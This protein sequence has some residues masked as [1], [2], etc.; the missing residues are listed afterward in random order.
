MSFDDA[1]NILKGEDHA[2]TDYL[3]RKSKVQLYDAFMPVIVEA[4]DE[5]NARTYWRSAVNAYNRLP[6]VKKLNPELDDHVNTQA[7]NGLFAL[8]AKK[9]E[10]IRNDVNQRS[11]DLLRKVFAKQDTD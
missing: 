4:L 1:M 2:A 6:F 10:G 3:N 7:L 11:T 8:I 9:E 5:V